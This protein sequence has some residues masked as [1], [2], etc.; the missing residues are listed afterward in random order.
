[1]GALVAGIGEDVRLMPMQQAVRLH[2]VRD[3]ARGA[4]HG[5]HQARICVH[6]NVRLHAK[7]PLASFLA[8]VHLGVA[9]LVFVLGRRWRCNQCGVYRCARFEQQALGR[10]Q[11]IDDGEDLLGQFVFLQ[12]VAKPE[13]GA[14]I[15]QASM[16]IKMRKL[17]VERYIKE[18]L[19]QSKVRE[20]KPLLQAVQA[21]HGLE[22][23]GWAA[24]L[25]FGVV[26]RDDR[27]Q[28]SPGNDTFHV[29]QEHLLARRFGAEVQIKAALV[30]GCRGCRRSL[31][32]N[33]LARRFCRMSLE[34][35]LIVFLKQ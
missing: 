17:S 22:L 9:L 8:R 13:D 7:V 14:L 19:F 15:G 31:T 27:D 5:M 25:A 16:G 34:A 28:G 21:Q 24:V 29:G 20:L 18:R 30:H 26:R 2:N 11:F 4:A 32:P 12:P 23:K 1:M 10:Q 35:A 3:I 6:P 33:R